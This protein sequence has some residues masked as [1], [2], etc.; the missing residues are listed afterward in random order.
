MKGLLL[1]ESGP[2]QFSSIPVAGLVRVFGFRDGP[3]GEEV[4]VTTGDQ[5]APA[6]AV[7][8]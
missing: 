6:Q 3:T 2:S 5:V 7:E 4:E 1:F 8:P